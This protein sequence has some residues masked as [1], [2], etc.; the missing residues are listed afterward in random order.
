MEYSIGA[1]SRLTGL[2]IHT[3][4]YYEQEQLIC[5]QRD[6][7]GR[8][9]YSEQDLLWIAFIRRLKDTG[10]PIREIRRYATLRAMG[11]AT[12]P[13]RLSLLEE[14]REKLDQQILALQAHQKKLDEKI[15]FYREAIPCGEERR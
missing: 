2:G 12:L 6:A 11:D 15:S 5:P 14:H 10:M 4:R 13:E 1:F 9:H 7:T 8:R 3:L